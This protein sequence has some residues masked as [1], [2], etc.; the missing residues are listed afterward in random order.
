MTA[1]HFA[2]S[3]QAANVAYDMTLA[4]TGDV[5]QAADDYKA[6]MT[7]YDAEFYRRII[8]ERKA[9]EASTAPQYAP[10][11]KLT[12][13]SQISRANVDDDYFLSLCETDESAQGMMG[14]RD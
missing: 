8:A 14:D 10:I 12:R 1:E 3:Q 6:V 7:A 4:A 13:Q 5:A 2:D 11:G 9:D